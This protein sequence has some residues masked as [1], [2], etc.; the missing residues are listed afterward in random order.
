[1]ALDG[2]GEILV[3]D[4]DSHDGTR[5]VVAD[6]PVKLLTLP[7]GKGKGA[8]RNEGAAH[9]AAPVLL[10]VDADVV[11]PPDAVRRVLNRLDSDPSITAVNGLLSEKCAYGDFFSKYKNL[12][13]Y[14]RFKD[15][16]DQIDFLFSSITAIRKESYI[17]FE[18]DIKPKDTE[19]G[20]RLSRE[21]KRIVF[22][23]HL[24]VLHLKRHDFFSLTRNDFAVPFGW[25]RVFLRQKGVK[26]VIATK[27]FAHAPMTQILTLLLAPLILGLACISFFEPTSATFFLTVA[28][29]WTVLNLRLFLYFGSAGGFWFLVQAVPFTFYDNLVMFCG[30]ASGFLAAIIGRAS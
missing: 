15:L 25:A 24:Q 3:V 10:L 19:A 29:I 26:D 2:L 12:Y 6:F 30:T 4:C 22:D 14:Y 1:M 9:A 23:R 7:P 13:M 5:R 17:S 18:D 16:P 8:A 28:A 21:G 11:V 20:K 27:R